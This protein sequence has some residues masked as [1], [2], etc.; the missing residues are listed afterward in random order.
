MIKLY[1]LDND[2]GCKKQTIDCK[3]L[4][5]VLHSTHTIQEDCTGFDYL[6]LYIEFEA[7]AANYQETCKSFVEFF[8]EM[9]GIPYEPI[10]IVKPMRHE[11]YICAIY[12][13]VV[14]N[15]TWL[16]IR[17]RAILLDEDDKYSVC[18][19]RYLYK[20]LPSIKGTC[21]LLDVNG[22]EYKG[23]DIFKIPVDRYLCQIVDW[24]QP[25]T[26]EDLPKI[27]TLEELDEKDVRKNWLEK[28]CKKDCDRMIEDLRN[29]DTMNKMLERIITPST[30]S[31][32]YKKPLRSCQAATTDVRLLREYRQKRIL[33]L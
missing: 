31:K 32:K 14:N 12:P 10:F 26:K 29:P 28:R 22:K 15:D 27:P 21:W 5:S 4:I 20:S 33:I 24:L 16:N 23:N 25:I 11:Y 18:N 17:G 2:K 3:N 6:K 8:S 19:V 7:S 9:T 13:C 30:N 1:Y